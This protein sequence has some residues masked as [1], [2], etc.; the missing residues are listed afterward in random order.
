[1]AELKQMAMDHTATI[2]DYVTSFER[3]L[4]EEAADRVEASQRKGRTA[5]HQARDAARAAGAMRLAKVIRDAR[6]D[7]QHLPVASGLIVLSTL[8][9]RAIAE[10]DPTIPAE[11]AVS[12]YAIRLIHVIDDW[13]VYIASL[14]GNHKPLN[15][16]FPP[17]PDEI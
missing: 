10:A 2:D 11:A 9:R 3:F 5:A 4:V 13:R 8:A 17:D 1:M 16:E 6:R 14:G 15:V 12:I 7:S